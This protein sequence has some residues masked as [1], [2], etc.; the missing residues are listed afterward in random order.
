MTLGLIVEN[1][2][3]LVADLTREQRELAISGDVSSRAYQNLTDQITEA[4]QVLNAQESELQRYNAVIAIAE[5][6]I[7]ATSLSVGLLTENQRAAEEAAKAAAAASVTHADGLVRLKAA[8]D[9]TADAFESTIDDASLQAALR[10]NDAY[11]NALITNAEVARDAA[12]EGSEERI[13]LD[14]EDIRVTVA[15][16]FDLD[17]HCWMQ[18]QHMNSLLY[19][20]SEMRE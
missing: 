10:A 19:K 5:Q 8:A 17:K 2:Q 12:K 14:A 3:Q 7:G 4:N 11:Y 6:N 16:T 15:N 20:I 13:K 9:D 1:Q 18:A